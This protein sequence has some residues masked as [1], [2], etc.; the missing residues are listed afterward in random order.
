MAAMAA[1]LML[2]QG[3]VRE[4]LV[5]RAA[6][7]VQ[8]EQVAAQAKPGPQATSQP[9]AHS[10]APRMRFVG[11]RFLRLVASELSGVVLLPDMSQAVPPST[12]AVVTVSGFDGPAA[13]L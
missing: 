12:I 2:G 10:R 13:L 6:L 7:V 1:V 5:G 11:I 8:V 3:L 4:A 9:K